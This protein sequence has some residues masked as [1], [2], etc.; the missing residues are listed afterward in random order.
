M[1]RERGKENEKIN[2]KEKE[3]EKGSV[4]TLLEAPYYG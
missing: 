1:E 3:K 2:G 4:G